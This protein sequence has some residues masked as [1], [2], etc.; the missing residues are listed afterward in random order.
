MSP[1]GLSWLI[2]CSLAAVIASVLLRIGIDAEP[3]GVRKGV[4]LI[5]SAIGLYLV[6]TV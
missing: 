1:L 3:L 2:F 4:R 5:S 6:S